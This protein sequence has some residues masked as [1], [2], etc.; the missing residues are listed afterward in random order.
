MVMANGE[1]LFFAI[2]EDKPFQIPVQQQAPKST[3]LRL[4][5]ALGGRYTPDHAGGIR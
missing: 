3:F 1:R 2:D 5:C 4:P